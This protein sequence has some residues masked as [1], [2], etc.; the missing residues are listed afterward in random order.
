[1]IATAEVSLHE[2]APRYRPMQVGV[3]TAMS[4]DPEQFVTGQTELSQSPAS[5][6]AVAALAW[7]SAF[8]QRSLTVGWECAVRNI[9]TDFG[10]LVSRQSVS[11]LLPVHS[12]EDEPRLAQH[13]RALLD[14]FTQRAPPVVEDAELLDWDATITPVERAPK[15]VYAS[16][17]YLGR[18]KPE[19]IE[20][21]WDY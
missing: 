17:R 5:G 21:P 12:P 13:W 10:D 16:V 8:K 1:M 7:E 2:I 11:H 6:L 18:P 14:A 3:S 9:S 20:D 19:P 4:C 15:V